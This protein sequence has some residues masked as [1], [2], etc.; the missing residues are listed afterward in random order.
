L[1]GTR[2]SREDNPRGVLSSSGETQADIRFDPTATRIEFRIQEQ[3][4]PKKYLYERQV[5][6]SLQRFFSIAVV[7]KTRMN[8]GTETL[9]Q[10]YFSCNL[11]NSPEQLCSKKRRLSKC[12][13]RS[14]FD[15]PML[16]IFE[17]NFFN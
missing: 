13:S 6:L 15:Y 4:S 7:L 5:L 9:L 16:P 14:E 8:Y 11:R 12:F 17:L 3:I 10:N 2:Y 1:L